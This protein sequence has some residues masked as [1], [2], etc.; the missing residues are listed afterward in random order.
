[1]KIEPEFNEN[2]INNSSR[3]RRK[4]NCIIDWFWDDSHI[5]W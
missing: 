1:L 5:N 4:W 2:W 3:K